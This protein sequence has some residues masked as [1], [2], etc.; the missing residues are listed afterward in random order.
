VK[1]GWRLAT[2]MA[3]AACVAAAQPP[4]Q[5]PRKPKNEEKE[6]ATQTLPLLKD[7]PAA[8]AA[9]T[10]KLAFHVSPLSA[11]GLL[12]PQTREAIGALMKMNRG[13]QIVKLRAFV[14]GTGDLRRVQSIVSEVFTEKKRPLP[15]LSAIQVG[16]L[17]LE[18]AQV[19][20]ESVS[21]ENKPV[22]PHG[23]VFFSGQK[24]GSAAEAVRRLAEKESDSGVAGAG[25][26][27]VTCFLGSVE[28]APA[29][30]G[31]AERAFPMAALNFVQPLRT[32]DG[33]SA[34]CEGVGSR[35]RAG[36]EVEVSAD[37][38]QVSAPKLVFSGA[39]MAFGGEDGDVRL[40]FQRLEKALEPLGV[41]Y[42]ELVFSSFYSLTR[43]MEEKAGRIADEFFPR[44][45][46]PAGTAMM[47]EGLPSL[48]ATAAVEVVAAARN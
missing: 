2:T 40:A 5:Q 10:S 8:V 31:E 29:A 36:A 20:I 4:P 21:V 38:A 34:V 17:T 12:S 25:M 26:L 32:E 22:H 9:E 1:S 19:V 44:E 42:R 18:G 30:R 28:Q 15:A 3:L 27:R 14:A 37:A 24:G 7:P 23:L 43:A 46:Q 13:A 35:G 47:F 11:K 45:R 6:P 48:D 16:A 33:N 39:Q 41:S